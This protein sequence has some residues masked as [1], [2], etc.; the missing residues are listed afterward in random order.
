ML[1][2][3]DEEGMIAISQPA[4]SWVA[5]QLARHW[6]HGDFLSV[7]EEVCLAS[8]QHDIG[9]LEWER[10]PTLNAET[11]LPHTFLEMP[12]DL[13]LEIWTKGIQEMLRFGRYPALLVSMHYT[14]LAN[15]NQR[16]CPPEEQKWVDEFLERQDALQITLQTSLNNDFYYEPV[17]SPEIL[18]RNQQLVSRWDWMSLLL[19][20][21]L[22]KPAEIPEI[23]ASFGHGK[24]TLTPE[25]AAGSPVR[26]SPW[27]FRSETV[28]I[29][30]EGRRLLKTY[31]DQAH[32]REAI[33][34]AAPVTLV[35]ELV[36]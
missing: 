2:R 5:G 24:L 33:R 7:P 21:R 14:W 27:P 19:C 22:T 18:R 31:R 3:A 8:E 10:N 1:H 29:V 34:A 15:R 35:I 28:G 32:L 13:R 11:G 4:H 26:V 23:P 30:C 36:K 6:G 12:R 25:S 16:E 17:S 9:Y 20:H